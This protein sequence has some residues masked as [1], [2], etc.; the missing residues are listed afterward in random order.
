[1]K[2]YKAL[3][4]FA[5]ASHLLYASS[6]VGNILT[7]V[8]ILDM[9]GDVVREAMGF[10]PRFCTF[11]PGNAGFLN[12]LSILKRIDPKLDV[13]PTSEPH[14]RRMGEMMLMALDGP[15]INELNRFGE[16][17]TGFFV[18]DVK[19]DIACL[20]G[21]FRKRFAKRYQQLYDCG[22]MIPIHP[23]SVHLYALLCAM[24]VAAEILCK[25]EC[26]KMPFNE[27]FV[28]EFLC[29]KL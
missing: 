18:Q 29:R 12:Y 2:K 24:Q 3:E 26:L 14:D 5:R 4:D 20:E 16:L 9:Q 28:G 23:H 13:R 27:Y 8:I 7:L 6:N 25:H 1:M 22:G 10:R 11:S 17:M 21:Q 15:N 19:T